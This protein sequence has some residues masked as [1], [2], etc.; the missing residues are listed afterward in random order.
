LSEAKQTGLSRAMRGNLNSAKHPWR[1]F[2]KRRALKPE[3]RYVLPLLEAYADGLLEDKGGDA[4][5]EATK[6]MIEL[7][8]LTR[9]AI[10]LVLAE[11]AQRGV[12][13]LDNDGT[14]DLQP[15]F[16]ELAKLMNVERGCLAELGLSRTSKPVLSL[17]DIK[18]QIID[19]KVVKDLPAGESQ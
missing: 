4:A 1:S 11:A 15:G 13:K 14:W 12:V 3:D 7:A 2:L 9:G 8:Q 6:R 18:A 17:S 16:R 5:P 19:A 10:M